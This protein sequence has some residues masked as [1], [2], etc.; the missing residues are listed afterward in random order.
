MET[1][2]QEV[3]MCVKCGDT[4]AI[5]QVTKKCYKCYKEDFDKRQ[6]S[7]NEETFEKV[8]E[9]KEESTS[10]SCAETAKL[11]RK[12]LKKEFPNQKFSVRS[13]TYSMGAS[14][15]VRWTDGVAKDKV[16]RV[17]KQFEGAGFDGMVDYKYYISHWMLPDG[18][19]VVAKSEGTTDCGGYSNGC[20]NPKPHPDAKK[21][22]FGA[23][24]VFAEREISNEI[25][26]KVAKKLAKLNNIEFV[27]LD[28]SV[29]DVFGSGISNWWGV[30]RSL[31]V[32]EDLTNFKKV[33]RT[34]VTCGN[35]EDFYKVLSK[36][37]E[38]YTCNKC[39]KM[40]PGDKVYSYVDGNNIA[41]TKNSPNYCY[42]CYK[43]V[44]N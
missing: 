33:V 8:E 7:V 30:V 4:P 24:Y 18:S 29:K 27:S 31:V 41:I 40:F 42:K 39:K 25:Y 36:G 37:V 22:S 38:Y 11:I 10:L 6:N 28:S 26:E 19:V 13:D 12:A 16:D 32:N 15:D 2:M 43:E 3:G 1:K 34:E 20:D 5:M 23:D 44:Y 21:V 17:V 14:I 35:W 9:T